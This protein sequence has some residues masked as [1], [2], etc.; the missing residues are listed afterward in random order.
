MGRWAPLGAAGRTPQPERKRVNQADDS[1]NDFLRWQPGLSPKPVRKEDAHRQSRRTGL[2]F[3]PL[4]LPPYRFRVLPPSSTPFLPPP[5]LPPP[6]TVERGVA[7]TGIRITVS[8]PLTAKSTS[9]AG[10]RLHRTLPFKRWC[11]CVFWATT[12]RWSVRII[13]RSPVCARTNH[14]SFACGC[15]CDRA[16]RSR[17]RGG[18]VTILAA[19]VNPEPAIFAVQVGAYRDKSNADRMETSMTAIYGAGRGHS[20]KQRAARMAGAGG[21]RTQRMR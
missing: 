1:A 9:D 8:G 5:A 20:S 6:G 17:S 7:G 4:F 13:D 14:R 3:L 21:A 16:D 19:P 18:R 15:G 11:E 2:P 12:R 10:G